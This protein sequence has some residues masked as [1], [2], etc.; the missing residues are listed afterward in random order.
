VRDCRWR[1]GLGG[2]NPAQLPGIGETYRWAQFLTLH[3]KV[4]AATA[5]FTVEVATW[6]GLLTYYVL[7]VME[8][9]T[10]QVHIAGMTPH[11]T[12]AFVQ[13]CARQLTNPINGCLLRKRYLIHDRDTKFPA[14][15]DGLLKS[16]GAEPVVL[17]PQSPNL[18]AHCE[19]FVRSIKEA[20]LR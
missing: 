5:F 1:P 12:A 16:S 11:P 17:P 13:Q 10:R 8:L 20:A 18:N 19:R 7:V 4:L 2:S 9:A 3:W 14:A 15:F 6:H